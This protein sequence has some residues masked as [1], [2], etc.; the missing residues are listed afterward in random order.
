MRN[1]FQSVDFY[2]QL[3]LLR[4]FRPPIRRAFLAMTGCIFLVVGCSGSGAV[5]PLSPT[6]ASQADSSTT[7]DSDVVYWSS[8]PVT[9][10]MTDAL[11]GVCLVSNEKGR[12]GS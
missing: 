1:P 10:S 6:K 7:S 5:S 2:F 8:F 12:V 11:N 4:H 9:F 3:G